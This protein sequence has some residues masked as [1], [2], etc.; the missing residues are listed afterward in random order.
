MKR[1]TI[2]AGLVLTAL[3]CGDDDTTGPSG[4]LLETPTGLRGTS[5][6]GAI[7]LTWNDNAF[8]NAPAE[9]FLEYRIWGTGYSLDDAQCDSDW[10]MEG[11]TIAPE[12]LVGALENGIPK[13]FAVASV[14]TDLVESPTS[15]PWADTP[16]PDARNVLIWAYQVDPLVSGFRF[17]DDVNGNGQ[18]D[19]LELG[20]VGDGN[21]TDIDFWLDRDVNGD[22]FMVPER[23]GTQMTFY[24]LDPIED[25]TSIDVA[26]LGGF[27]RDAY[28]AVPMYGYVFEMDGG[29][30][31]A[32]YGA[33]RVTHVGPEFMIFDWAYQTDPGNPELSIHGGL[34][35]AEDSG[36]TVKRQ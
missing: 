11:S 28:Q 25:L 27:T 10:Y 21:R 34:A 1:A 31:F 32:R 3:A 17:F 9:T 2:F 16:R 23:S 8:L 7:Y 6:N 13:C 29:D 22:F 24:D 35:V 20:A 26:P 33:I 12:F 30:G 5:L 18:V 15:Q 36:I 14:S 19:P 4:V